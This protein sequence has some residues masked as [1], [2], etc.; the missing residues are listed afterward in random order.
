MHAGEI[1]EQLCVSGFVL[2]GAD[3]VATLNT[4]LWKRSGAGGPFRRL[5]D[6]IYDLAR[7]GNAPSA[8]EARGAVDRKP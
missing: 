2:P 8:E 3:P 7:D 6:A 5:G 1:L 4:R